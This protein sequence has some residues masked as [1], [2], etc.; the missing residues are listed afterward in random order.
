MDFNFDN[1]YIGLGEDFFTKINPEIFKK[2]KLIAFNHEL[3]EEMGG[4]KN[5]D[6]KDEELVK[7]F[8]GQKLFK[9][10]SPIAQVYAGHQFG[11]FNPRLGDG[12]AHLLGEVLTPDSKRFDLQLKGCGQTP[13]S[14][15]GDGRSSI[16]PVLRE[17]ILSEAMHA[18][19]IKTTR[20]LAAAWSGENIYRQELEPGGI[21]T[22]VASSHIRIGT[23]QYFLGK[24]D[25]SN[26][27]KLIHYTI[28]RLY[29]EA[30]S[31]DEVVLTFFRK[32][33]EQLNDLVSDWLAIGFIHGVMNTDNTSLSGETI[34]YGPCA[35]MDHFQ[36]DKVYSFV[37]S[38]GRYRYDR[39]AEILQWNLARLAECLI[40]EVDSDEKKS[41]ALLTEELEKSR[42]QIARMWREKSAKKLGILRPSFE[43]EKLI[44]EWFSILE[45]NKLDFTLSFIHL[46]DLLND[47]DSSF[48][49][50]NDKKLESFIVKL[51]K[52]LQEY[53]SL[54]VASQMKK[55]NPHFIPR[56][57]IVEK[58]IQEALEN[59]ELITF[60]RLNQALKN[61]YVYSEEHKDFYLPPKPQEVVKATFCGT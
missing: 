26:L 37:D 21:F 40:H 35:F 54:D 22:R 18:L 58:A 2:A 25:Y 13:Y 49:P 14:R 42:E 1:T 39:Q 48:F 60:E 52:R 46:R 12:R 44:R 43:D 55:L 56:N 28:S 4:Q 17:Y 33:C 24:G 31:S 34:D 57:H 32:V 6:S 59:K 27:S 7:Y 19:G 3:F 20:A 47:K 45:E 16:G 15:R 23:F 8:S 5:S 36:S 53:S 30:R 41:I 10:S 51:K 11:H 61:P 9:G 38:Q 50:E 29:P